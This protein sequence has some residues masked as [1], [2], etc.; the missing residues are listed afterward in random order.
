MVESDTTNPDVWKSYGRAIESDVVELDEV[1]GWIHLVNTCDAH[2]FKTVVV[3][4]PA[5]SNAAVQTH[6]AIL[7]DSLKE[8]GRPLM[9]LWV[10][11]RQRDS[12]ELL[13]GKGLS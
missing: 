4:T 7:L 6:G 3:N 13:K 5:R 12:L 9:T 2:S 8:L 10:I 11:N 1:D